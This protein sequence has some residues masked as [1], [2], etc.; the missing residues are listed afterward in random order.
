MNS[1]AFRPSAPDQKRMDGETPEEGDKERAEWPLISSSPGLASWLRNRQISIACSSYQTGQLLLVGC[2]SDGGINVDQQNHRRAMGLW[3]QGDQLW[4]G[5]R[6][7][8]WRLEN[9]LGP[10]GP[11]AGKF[12]RVF[13]PRVAYTTGAIDIHELGITS[14]DGLIFVNTRFSCLAKVD[15]HHSFSPVWKPKFVT[16]LEPE[17][18]CHLNGLCIEN[19]T[20]RF[21]T[22]AGVSDEPYGWRASKQDGGVIIDVPTGETVAAGL[23]MPHSPR[24]SAGRLYVL[25]SGRGNLVEVDLR[26]GRKTEIAFGQ[27]FL[28]GLAIVG[29]YA[30]VGSSKPRDK[31]F[32]N[33]PLGQA[34]EQRDL[35]PW[36]AIMIFDLRS[37]KM[38]EWLRFHSRIEETFDVA[39]LPGVRCPMSVGVDSGQIE[40]GITF[41]ELQGLTS[42]DAPRDRGQKRGAL[43]KS[44]QTP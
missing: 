17:D 8:V 6:Y 21:V 1:A 2:N 23:S 32:H 16:Q 38:V 27:G 39:V 33:L 4:L 43:E 19:G 34:L 24:L 7:Q 15:E 28:R 12:D 11:Q 20:V 10:N 18:R 13:V 14:A 5:T 35:E 42:I 31:H 29:S 3:F 44:H 37:G 26:S 30:I 22:A 36:C 40:G 41:G 25:D 9:T